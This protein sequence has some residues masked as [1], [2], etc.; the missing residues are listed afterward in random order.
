MVKCK[1]ILLVRLLRGV[2]A[3][4]SSET[5]SATGPSVDASSNGSSSSCSATAV[6]AVL[7][8]LGCCGSVS[9]LRVFKLGP[10]APTT[11][12][13]L[14]DDYYDGAGS[15]ACAVSPGQ[16]TPVPMEVVVTKPKQQHDRRALT[17]WPDGTVGTTPSTEGRV[18]GAPEELTPTAILAKQLW[19]NTAR[20]LEPSLRRVSEDFEQEVHDDNG[21]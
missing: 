3:G 17:P 7:L 10:F 6:V 9:A 20:T 5:P 14:P 16:L 19:A 13:L 21:V 8:V 1:S 12:R 11:T 4:G 15:V 18:T 2:S